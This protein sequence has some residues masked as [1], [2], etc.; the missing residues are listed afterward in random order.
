MPMR[1]RIR[2]CKSKEEQHFLYLY[3][4]FY[5]EMSPIELH[6]TVLF[7]IY[8]KERGKS[9]SSAKSPKLMKNLE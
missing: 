5:R 6:S 7:M 9:V 1:K 2:T 8:S 3:Y 4:F